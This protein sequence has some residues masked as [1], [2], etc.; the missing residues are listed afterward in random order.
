MTSVLATYRAQMSAGA[1]EAVTLSPAI[2]TA[3]PAPTFVAGSPAAGSGGVAMNPI[4]ALAQ[5]DWLSLLPELV[6]TGVASVILLLEAFTPRLRPAFN[7]LALA[8][9]AAASV[10]LAQQPTG[11]FFHGLIESTA[12]T[13]A[14]SQTIL[15]ATAIGLLSAQ[16]YLKRERLLFGEYPALLLWCSTGLLLLVRGVELVTIFVALELLSVAL[17]GLAAFH[18]RGVGFVRGR[19]QVLP[20]G[21]AGELLRSLRRRAGLR[22]NRLDD[23]HRDLRRA[24]GR[25]PAPPA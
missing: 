7:G 12:L 16:G 2:L 9:V 14:F 8:G 6:L 25:L 13:G 3:T 17:Y 20:D 1:P 19:D 11:L 5:A 10:I 4:F 18:R 15:L 23:H 24:R 22:R 21:R